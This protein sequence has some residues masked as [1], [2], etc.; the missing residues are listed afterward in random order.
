MKKLERLAWIERTFG[1]DMVS[2]YKA[3]YT[4]GQIILALSGFWSR[5]D[6]RPGVRT[7]FIG[8]DT[9]GFNLPFVYPVSDTAGVEAVRRIWLGYSHALVYIVSGSVQPV[10][11]Q[12]V[13]E[14]LDDEHVFFEVNDKEPEVTQRHMYDHPQNL[15]QFVL[16]PSSAYIRRDRGGERL[17]PCYNPEWGAVQSLDRIYAAMYQGGAHELTFSIKMN[18][19]VILW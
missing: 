8:G 19:R 3:C 13:A 6:P 17:F 12:G 7:D 18:K 2:P 15:R 5:G 4:W 14:R 1:A 16:G 11:T 10:L 9:Q